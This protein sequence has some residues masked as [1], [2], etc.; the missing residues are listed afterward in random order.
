M[1]AKLISLVFACTAIIVLSGFVFAGWDVSPTHYYFANVPPYETRDAQFTVHNGGP[2]YSGGGT[3]SI[4]ADV[5]QV[6]SCVSGCSY[7]IGPGEDHTVTIRFTASRCPGLS[8]CNGGATIN[9]PT[10]SGT[11]PRWIG[12]SVSGPF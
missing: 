12:V 10:N 1:K 8:S 6:W 7:Y 5:P 11:I 2:G 4:S 3:V 9:F